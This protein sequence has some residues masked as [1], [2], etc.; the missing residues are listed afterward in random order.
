MRGIWSGEMG[1]S[2]ECKTC[3]A[4]WPQG[5]A[6]CPACHTPTGLVH[7]DPDRSKFQA[8]E[9]DFERK[10][11]RREEKRI[12]DGHLAPEALGKREARQIIELERGLREAA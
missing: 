11:A 6:H 3:H 12:S 2:R 8:L 7:R 5:W 10:Y 9:A 4:R 1:F